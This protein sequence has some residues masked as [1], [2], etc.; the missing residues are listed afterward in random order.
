MA[1]AAVSVVMS[2]AFDAHEHT[3]GSPFW[4]DYYP[5][6]LRANGI[7]FNEVYS[8]SRSLKS[9]FGVSSDV[10]LTLRVKVSLERN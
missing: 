9:E 7:L 3:P 1:A 2:T 10:W 4:T 5:V 8:I 6:V